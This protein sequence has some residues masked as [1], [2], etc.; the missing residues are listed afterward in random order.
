[1]I[2]LFVRLFLLITTLAVCTFAAQKQSPW[3]EGIPTSLPLT[4]K[5]RISPDTAI[6]TFGIK[7]PKRKWG[8]KK[9]EK[10]EYEETLG[11]ST[12]S[13]LLV[14]S[15]RGNGNQTITRPYTPISK[16]DKKKS[17]DLL[18]KAYPDGLMGQ[19][20]ESLK[21]GDCMMFHQIPF[22][23][24]EQ[25][26]F[27]N[28][29][30]IIMLAAGTGITPMYQALQKIFGERNSPTIKTKIYLLYSCKT[31]KDILLHHE[32]ETMQRKYPDQLH[33]QYYVSEETYDNINVCGNKRFNLG[34]IN[35]DELT[36]VCNVIV[37][38]SNTTSG[39][40]RRRAFRALDCRVWVCGPP[41]FYNAFCGPR[42][43]RLMPLDCILKKIGFQSSK[44]MKF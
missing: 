20:F 7:P 25:F 35:M 26:P 5:R 13:C 42:G 17:F 16:E 43:D 40:K 14:T 33:I 32:L 39:V 8:E 41:S 6:Y 18:V 10:I 9:R 2:K 1:M 28:P 3:L 22:N 4:N 24:K 27:D 23:I 31:I 34:K 11:I 37:P 19:E 29:D 44:V 15:Q 21:T 30:T 36:K 38:E 12:C